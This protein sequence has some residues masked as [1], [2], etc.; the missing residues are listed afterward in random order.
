MTGVGERVEIIRRSIANVL[1]AIDGDGI[2]RMN[3][4]VPHNKRYSPK[5]IEYTGAYSDV[6]LEADYKNKNVLLCDLTFW[7]VEF[8]Y[9]V[10]GGLLL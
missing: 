2:L 8:L 4:S 6:R 10:S 7:A 1:R 9:L 3:F 5:K